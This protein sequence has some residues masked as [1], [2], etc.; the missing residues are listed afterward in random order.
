MYTERY[1]GMY[2]ENFQGY[3]NV[4]LIENVDRL[5]GKEFMIVHG[6]L[7]RNV[8][9]QHSAMLSKELQRKAILFKQQVFFYDAY[10]AF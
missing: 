3:R 1:M 10:D 9:F 4:S 6:L 7:D 5:R 8:L 2:K